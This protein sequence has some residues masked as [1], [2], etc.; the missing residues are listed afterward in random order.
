MKEASHPW[1]PLACHPEGRETTQ[2]N[3][4]AWEGL[5]TEGFVSDNLCSPRFSNDL[6]AAEATAIEISI[7]PIQA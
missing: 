5:S 6:I 1:S 2:V 3:G 4:G 7:F